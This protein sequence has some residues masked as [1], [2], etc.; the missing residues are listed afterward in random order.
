MGTD[1]LHKGCYVTVVHGSGDNDFYGRMVNS[2]STEAE[3]Q[4]HIKYQKEVI[5]SSKH[6]SILHIIDMEWIDA[7]TKTN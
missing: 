7:E 6:W 3:A 2:Y 1:S 5:G 4:D